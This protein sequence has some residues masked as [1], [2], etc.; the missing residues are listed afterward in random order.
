MYRT[1]CDAIPG[2][3]DQQKL[4]LLPPTTARLTGRVPAQFLADQEPQQKV[5]A[6]GVQP[7]VQ[8]ITGWELCLDAKGLRSAG[9]GPRLSVTA[10]QIPWPR[11]KYSVTE[12]KKKKK[13]IYIFYIY[14]LQT[15]PWD[16][17]AKNPLGPHRWGHLP[18]RHRGGIGT[19]V[20]PSRERRSEVGAAGEGG[21][22]SQPRSTMLAGKGFG[23]ASASG[24]G[25]RKQ[26]GNASKADSAAIFRARQLF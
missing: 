6:K 8:N 5:I 7:S 26:M 23:R 22:G 3:K 24:V 10:L 15:I 14:L 21:C 17:P 9:L 11:R 18:A 19:N 4:P 25:E 20:L 13:K 2:Q 16:L 12:G 1:H